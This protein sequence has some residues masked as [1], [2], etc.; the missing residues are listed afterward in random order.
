M[1]SLAAPI[2][3]VVER[4]EFFV[5]TES[6][7]LLY[8][9][10]S[11]LAR[12][13]VLRHL[14]ATELLDQNI[15][16]F[17]VLEAPTESSDAGW[18]ARSEEL[19]IDWQELVDSAPAGL[20]LASLW[21][22]QRADSPLVRFVGE[23]H[24]AL[25]RCPARLMAGLT[26][27]LAPLWVTDGARFVSDLEQLLAVPQIANARFIVV[28][29]NTTHG[30]ALAKALGTSAM[31]VDARVDDSQLARESCMRVAAMKATQPGATGV[32]LTGAAG[33][34][35]LPPPRINERR[36]TPEQRA[37]V[38]RSLGMPPVLFETDTMQKVTASV[39][40][41]AQ[42]MR[43]GNPVEAI[44]QQREVLDFCLVHELH[45]ESVI[46]ELVLAGYVL[47][48]GEPQRALELFTTARERARQR[49]FVELAVQA[50]MAR[51][52]CLALLGR[53]EAA[54]TA[55]VEAGELGSGL[56]SPMLSVEAYRTAGQLLIASGHPS[57]AGTAFHR[58]IETAKS[59]DAATIR[60]SSAEQAMREL[61]ALCR[62]HG[63]REQAASLEAQA[64]MLASAAST[65]PSSNHAT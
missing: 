1:D 7:R 31:I 18:L 35:V 39:L 17:F 38:A 37:V 36:S 63:L 49:E 9:A 21:P 5:R 43:D 59:S 8:V 4:S 25:A 22:E 19:R 24:D 62:D 3:R 20:E 23:I 45:R 54:A 27:V 13:S 14:T 53:R 34:A 50:E 11:D 56:A 16:P 47:Q 60:D 44:R 48:A 15:R 41:A 52:S 51:G 6:I 28:E 40:A 46:H 26:I 2:E 58:A 30:L 64:D 61:A 29:S 55:Y 10:T 12:M 42:A 33:P 65:D 32:L 57:E